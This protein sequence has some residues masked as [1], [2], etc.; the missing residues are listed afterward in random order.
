[1]TG[2]GTVRNIIVYLKE[3]KD[4][5]AANEVNAEGLEKLSRSILKNARSIADNMSGD[6][7]SWTALDKKKCELHKCGF[8]DICHGRL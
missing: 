2:A 6:V 7:S 8:C 5:F 1:M 4:A 3:D